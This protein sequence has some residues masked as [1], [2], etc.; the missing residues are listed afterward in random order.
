MVLS[1]WVNVSRAQYSFWEPDE[2]FAIEVSLENTELKRLPI[3]RNSIQ[4]L[5]VA[6]DYIIGGT[7]AREG[8]SPFVL[9]ASLSERKL[10]DFEDIEN[11]ISGQRSIRS[12][13]CAGENN[14][15]FAGTIANKGSDNSRGDGHLMRIKIDREGTV[16][17]KN[18]GVPIPG[19]GIF[20]LTCDAEGTQLFGISYPTGLFFTYNIKT[21]NSRIFDD[22]VPTDEE[23]RTF[24]DYAQTP[25][26]YLGAALIEDDRGMI[27]GSKGLNEIFYFD[28]KNNSFHVLEDKI[29]E[30]WGR[31]SLGQIESWAKSEDGMLYGGNAGD[32]QLFRLD[33]SS[34]RVKNLGKPI[35][36]PRIRGLTFGKDG[37]LYG[38]AGGAPGYGHLFSYDQEGEG[39]HVYGNPQF[40]MVAPGIEQGI[41][42]RGFNLSTI[43]SSENGKYIV[44]GEDEALSQLL[45]FAIQ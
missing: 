13:F 18:L 38:V 7:A 30:V 5:T 31:T 41:R 8:L 35:M 25:D 28:P 16:E 26:M 22:L 1:S 24:R 12:G 27:Y 3:Y 29:P 14:S 44:M 19:E 15:F 42:W 45:I 43:G 11:V 21:G 6:G 34:N 39:Y 10:I 20:S 36:M 40:T 9:V 23:L 2:A 4:S 17:I 33:P 32:G 37:K